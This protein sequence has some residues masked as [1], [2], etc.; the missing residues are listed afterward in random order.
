[1][2]LFSRR[3][4]SRM[5]VYA[6]SL[7][8]PLLS[9]QAAQAS[10][11]DEWAKFQQDVENACR[12]AAN[13]A[14]QVK[15]I[16][17]DPYGSETYGF[18]L[19]SGVENGSSNERLVACA[20]DKRSQI[21]EIS[22][23]FDG[24]LN[25]VP[26]SGPVT[27]GPMLTTSFGD[28]HITTFDGLRYDFQTAGDFL[29]MSNKDRTFQ[30]QERNVPYPNTPGTSVTEAA[31]AMVDGD[32]I[33]VYF[34]DSAV[35]INGEPL[36]VSAAYDQRRE[37]IE[38][39]LPH[40]ALLTVEPLGKT[41]R[42]LVNRYGPDH[43]RHGT[44]HAFRI[45]HHQTAATSH[46]VQGTIDKADPWVLGLTGISDGDRGNDLTARSGEIL[47][48]PA[49][50]SE[51]ERI[52]ATW[53]VTPEESLFVTR[54]ATSIPEAAPAVELAALP[55]EV[56]T[57]AAIACATGGVTDIYLLRDC[58]YDVAATGDKTFAT[59]AADMQVDLVEN[60]DPREPVPATGLSPTEEVGEDVVSKALAAAEEAAASPT[61][62]PAERP[63]SRALKDGVPQRVV[64]PAAPAAPKSDAAAVDPEAPAVD[65]PPPS[66]LPRGERLT[67]NGYYLIFQEDGNLCVY[68]EA[69]DGWVWCINND[70]SIRFAETAT[71]RTTQAGQLVGQDAAGVVLYALPTETPFNPVGI[72]LSTEGALEVYSADGVLW[73]SAN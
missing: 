13:L 30:L 12:T 37:K 56:R 59:A 1:M 44:Y 2:S 31:A 36:D 43:P 17:V 67:Q 6:C 7:M 70:P 16:Q 40:G 53:R 68:R 26:P 52:G 14:L 50:Q 5:A 73:S 24:R 29:L 62:E 11:S 10:S 42:Y 27:T 34:P 38:H 32:R 45:T 39:T 25:G 66:D 3:P 54:P 33:E 46:A 69:D 22:G 65:I 28:V 8:V 21:A 51:I 58:T 49:S 18:A 9:A 41:V 61:P 20:Y 57:E 47:Q 4:R 60:P 15:N 35:Y 48:L 55:V 19:L 71:V 72:R 23:P 63:A 64:T